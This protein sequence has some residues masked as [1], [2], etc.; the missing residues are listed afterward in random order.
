MPM[1]NFSIGRDVV[2][3]IV[4]QAGLVRFSLI[5][6]FDAKPLYQD[7]R[8]KGLDGIVRPGYLPEGWEG[9]FDLERA[10]SALDD[11][12]ASLESQYYA[13]LNIQPNSIMETIT[14]V[15]GQISQYRFSGVALKLE[16]AGS[17]KG[18]GTVKQKLGFFAS[19]RIK[20][21]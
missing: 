6:M 21:Q 2:L 15:G 13:G 7:I 10:D 19:R 18:D 20:V 16:D 1:N 8:I 3:D 14:E 5:T 17:W 4:G 12:F 11:Y 9:S